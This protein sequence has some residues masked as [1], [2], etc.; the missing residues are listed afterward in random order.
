MSREENVP[1][2]VLYTMAAL[3]AFIGYSHALCS[4]LDT[5]DAKQEIP[6]PN[7]VTSNSYLPTGFS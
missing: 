1:S 2:S 5:F 6:W 7:Q 4:T 3:L